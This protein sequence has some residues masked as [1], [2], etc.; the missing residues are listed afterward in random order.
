M[1]ADL[2]VHSTASDGTPRPPSSSPSRSSAASTCS[3]SPTTTP[4]RASPR[5]CRGRRTPALTL[6]PGRRALRRQRRASTSTSSATSSTRRPAAPRRSS[7]TCAPRGCARAEAMVG[8]L[9]RRRAT[10]SRST[11]CSRSPTAAPSAGATS[12]AR[13]SAA[14]HAESVATPSGASSAG[15]SRSTS[16]RTAD[17]PPRSSRRSAT[18]AGFP[19]SR[20]RASRGV[21][22]LIAELVAAGLA[23]HRGV[24]RRP[25]R[26]AARRA[27]PSM[28]ARL[29][30]LVTGGT[31]LPRRRTRRTRR[32]ARS[33]CPTRPST[34][35][36]RGGAARA[37]ALAP[38]RRVLHS[39]APWR[40]T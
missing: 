20:T 35:L 14:E 18:R 5:R 13:S 22:D 21:D 4:S 6:D 3:R 9:A 40:P 8:A 23:R 33:T 12:R 1:R 30:L 10:T 2:H 27:T 24:P 11:T 7:R 39:L 16:P 36:A 32:S 26:R 25:H 29:G 19:C 34:A 37:S 31:R 28:A 38:A 15:D 17:R